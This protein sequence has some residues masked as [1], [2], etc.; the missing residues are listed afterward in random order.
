MQEPLQDYVPPSPDELDLGEVK[1]NAG[2]GGW[3]GGLGG[4]VGWL[5]GWLVG[6]VKCVFFWGMGLLTCRCWATDM[7]YSSSLDSLDG[8]VC[9][10]VKALF[11]GLFG[12]SRIFLGT[13]DA[14]FGK[15]PLFFVPGCV[16]GRPS[17][18]Q[19]PVGEEVKVDFKL[20]NSSS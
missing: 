4:L 11:N 5:V 6:L 17:G 3:L 19:V 15:A 9:S 12:C 10:P 18:P 16:L 2:L 20:N 13:Y 1:R 7:L 8:P 14:L